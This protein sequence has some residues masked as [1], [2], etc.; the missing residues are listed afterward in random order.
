M[1][2]RKFEAWRKE[3][4]SEKA[5]GRRSADSREIFYFEDYRGPDG[6][7]VGL[8]CAQNFP[9]AREQ[10]SRPAEESI[11][12]SMNIIVINSG[13]NGNAVYVESRRS[14]SAVLLDC[15]LSRR[16]IEIRLKVH[17]RFLDRVRAVFIS[18]EHGDHVRGLP[19]VLRTYPVPVYLTEPT[20]RNLWAREMVRA[21]KFMEN[22]GK[23]KVED[24]TVQAVPKSHDAAD[25]V[26]FLVTTGGKRFLYSTDLGT[27][28]R[29]LADLLPTVEALL[30]ESNY[31]FDMLWNGDYPDALKSR[32]DSEVGHLSNRQAME[33]IETHCD[34][35]LRA[36]ILGH[37]SEN[38][39]TTEKVGTAIKAMLRRKPELT[40]LVLI[41]SRYNVSDVITI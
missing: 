18:H 38:N 37:I 8:P 41:A 4:N 20:H 36:L 15:G 2:E 25:P 35:R 24:I 16:Q 13:S 28:S 32:V 14:G 23:V 34:G 21:P 31:D 5:S 22:T 10:S 29:E 40:P 33:L 26:S 12:N 11:A 6:S 30:L 9:P 27:H 1:P 19:M 39:N 3:I 7:P 17:G